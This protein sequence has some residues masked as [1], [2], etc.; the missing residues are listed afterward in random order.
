MRKKDLQIGKVYKFKDNHK[1][2][3]LPFA[4]GRQIPMMRVRILYTENKRFPSKETTRRYTGMSTAYKLERG[5]GY[6]GINKDYEEK[7][8]EY[9]GWNMYLEEEPFATA[10]KNLIDVGH[11][12]I[13]K[14]NILKQL[15]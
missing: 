4:V 5:R 11:E 14:N 7:I 6:V 1:I 12:V 13:T 2:L 15:V 8:Y 3:A 9:Y 10:I